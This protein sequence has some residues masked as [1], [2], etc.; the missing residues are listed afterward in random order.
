[1]NRL[2]RGAAFALTLWLAAAAQAE[3]VVGLS[4]SQQLVVFDSVNPGVVLN[5]SPAISGLAAGD[6]ISDI[7]VFPVDRRLY[8]LGNSGRL[9]QINAYTGAATLDVTPQ[10]AIP[11]GARIDFNPAADRLRVIAGQNNFR[12]TPSRNTAGPTGANAGQVSIDGTLSG[13]SPVGDVGAAAYTNNFDGTATTTLYS[14]NFTNDQLLVHSGAPQ[15]S[16]LTTVGSLG[17]DL[18]P[19]AGFDISPSGATL[20]SSGNSLYTINLLSGATTPAGAI[21][22]ALSLQSVAFVPEPAT[23]SLLALAGLAALRRR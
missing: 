9:Y 15:F 17:I 4:T 1:M 3:L 16:T 2:F 12:L 11:A 23:I 10:S 13:P 21:G 19:Q 8:G 6:S 22:T 14:L 18:S 20:V 7:D 5:T